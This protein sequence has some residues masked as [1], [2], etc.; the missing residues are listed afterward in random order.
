M[1]RHVDAGYPARLRALP[2]A[3]P[4]L[5]VRHG[6]HAP[7]ERGWPWTQAAH[8][9]AIVGARA[10]RLEAVD[11]AR[12]LA[13]DLAGRGV[14][15]VSGGALGVDAAAHRGALDSHA[16]TGAGA[17]VAVFGCGIDVVYP[18]Q[19]QGLFD[20]IRA[21]GGVL[22]SQ[23]RPG[24]PPRPANFVRRNAVIAGLADAVVVIGAGAT[25]GALH[26]AAAARALGR[27]VAAMPGSAGCDA[28]IAHGAAVVTCAADV[29]Q[30]LAGTPRRPSADL[31]AQGSLAARVLALLHPEHACA[32]G[33]IATRAGL[34][35]R[36]VARA[37][38]GLEL[39]GLAIARPGQSYVR[40]ALAEE[41]L[42][43]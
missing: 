4:E 12:S 2:D 29:W 17:T 42:A 28:L 7:G 15:I 3:P 27:V 10:A 9:V 14:M 37:L 5:H 33:D 20:E 24:T 19:H 43:S 18:A 22:L 23:F 25:S 32:C 1:L 31:P 35:S 13:R 8:S 36:E 21:A 26:T 11:Q 41:L 16:A 38:T 6:D 34:S 40:S 30:A 39:E